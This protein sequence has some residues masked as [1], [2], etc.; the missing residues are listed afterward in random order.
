M[1]EDVNTLKDLMYCLIA[2]VGQHDPVIILI[3]YLSKYRK[4]KSKIHW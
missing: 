2:V 4:I 1:T 3:H